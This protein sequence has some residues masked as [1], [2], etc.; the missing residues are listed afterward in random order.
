M[1]V[2]F[3]STEEL[4]WFLLDPA[5]FFAYNFNI[6][7]LIDFNRI[8]PKLD[9]IN[10]FV[11]TWV[12]FYTWHAKIRSVLCEIFLNVFFLNSYSRNTHRNDIPSP[13]R[14]LIVSLRTLTITYLTTDDTTIQYKY[15]PCRVRG[16]N[17]N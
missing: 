4:A 6:Y 7:S 8:N 5:C 3:T 11:H 12:L 9:S 17:K 1:K 10:S 16:G 14:P 13:T 15:T 2:L